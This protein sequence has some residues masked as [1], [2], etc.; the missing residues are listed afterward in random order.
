MVAGQLAHKAFELQSGQGG[1]E[2]PRGQVGGFAEILDVLVP[3][4]DGLKYRALKS[5]TDDG[6]TTY[7]DDE[8]ALTYLLTY[9]DGKQPELAGIVRVWPDL[10]DHIRAAIGTL[11]GRRRAQGAGSARENLHN[12]HTYTKP[13]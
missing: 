8:T 10:P 11:A 5:L 3:V 4:G 7:D 1:S 6:A 9:L 12:L 2:A 13:P